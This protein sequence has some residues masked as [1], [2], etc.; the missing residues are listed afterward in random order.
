MKKDVP[1]FGAH[2]GI[3]FAGM[4]DLSVD[5]QDIIQSLATEYHG[6]IKRQV[7]NLTDLVVHAQ[8]AG[9]KEGKDKRKRFTLHVRAL[10]PGQHFE[11]SKCDDYE[12]PRAAHRCFEEILSQ[13]QHKLRTDATRPR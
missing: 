10:S 11:S 9:G 13:I 7:Q 12:L 3:Q 5:E 1:K 6:K 2:E 4:N 8:V